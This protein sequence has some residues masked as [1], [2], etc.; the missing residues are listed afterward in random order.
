MR[1]AGASYK[2]IAAAGGG[3]L[4]TVKATRQASEDALASSA[5]A[6]LADFLAEGV[7][8]I[9]IKS[10]YGLEPETEL[11]MPSCRPARSASGPSP[12][13]SCSPSRT[14]AGAVAW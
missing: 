5:R 11:R 2:E 8:T 7:T 4:S 6:R 10:G 14:G 1:L 3:I 9:E 13:R 12:I